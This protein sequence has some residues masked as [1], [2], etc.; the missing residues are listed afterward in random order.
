MLSLLEYKK[1]ASDYFEQHGLPSKADEA[2]HYTSLKHLPET[3]LEAESASSHISDA[4]LNTLLSKE[5]NPDF[6]NL[7][8]INGILNESLSD[9]PMAVGLQVY[10]VEN[11][12]ANEIQQA[13]FQVQ[14]KIGN[15]ATDSM[16]S[17]NKARNSQTLVIEV[18]RDH[19]PLKPLQLIRYSSSEKSVYSQTLIRLNFGSRLSVVETFIGDALKSLTNS[20]ADVLVESSATLEFVRV[21]SESRESTHVGRTR[22]YLQAQA[23]LEALSYAT[24]ARLSRHTLEVFCLGEQATA[25]I[26]GMTLG[27]GKQ[28]FDNH[29]LIDHVAGACITSQ[30]Y[31]SILDGE[32]RAVFNGRVSI[33]LGSQKA[34]SEQLNHNLLLSSQ[35]E[36]DSKPELGIYADDV[37]A[38]HG[39]TVGQLDAEELFYFLSRAIPREKAIEMM[40]LGFVNELIDRISHEA[41]RDWLQIRLLKA[42]Q[43]MKGQL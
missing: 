18:F 9:F 22:F 12:L 4:T 13:V 21:Q 27:T 16:E 28:H 8:I 17:L 38:T 15:L 36:A 11:P 2:W 37:K 33:R 10:A 30:L 1:Q 43:A 7:V 31:K 5:K 23:N 41:I 24:G 34:F 19:A 42:Y 14:Q 39:S 25:K 40:S 29:T 35:A 20:S 32:S 26:N 6:Y 3:A